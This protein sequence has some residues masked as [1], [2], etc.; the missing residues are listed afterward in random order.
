[1]TAAETW[2]ASF[3]REFPSLTMA[4][5]RDA[6]CVC[7]L[8]RWV[9]LVEKRQ[10]GEWTVNQSLRR[11]LPNVALSQHLSA[12]LPRGV[13]LVVNS[14]EDWA[15][16]ESFDRAWQATQPNGFVAR[17]DGWKQ[18]EEEEKVEECCHALSRLQMRE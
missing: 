15:V 5:V 13:C 1:M 4:L 6:I 8:G 11:M 18:R 12:T 10:S 16:F 3:Q 9:K 14:A 7:I 2:L 17:V